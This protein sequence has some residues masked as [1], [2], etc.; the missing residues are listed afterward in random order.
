MKLTFRAAAI[1]AVTFCAGAVAS[2]TT[3]G[4]AFELQDAALQQFNPQE[5][6]TVPPPPAAAVP[7]PAIGNIQT[8]DSPVVADAS[9]E[10]AID[11][12]FAS[13]SEAVDAQNTATAAD[14]ELRCLATGVYYESKGEP[15]AG[16]LAVAN[17]ILNRA[18]S[19]RY[20]RSVCSVLTQRGQ[21]SFVRGGRLPTP[22]NDRAWRRALAVAQVAERDLWE[23][24]V[25]EALFFHANYVSPNWGRPRVAAI[26]NHIFY[27]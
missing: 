25:P 10:D 18:A 6:E 7:L 4:F 14:R 15:L 21:F 16:Q 12:E 17:V 22:P 1:A 11:A 23:S 3:P 5:L 24:P 2:A 19:G 26:G 20:P 9:E 8:G 13:L 27:R